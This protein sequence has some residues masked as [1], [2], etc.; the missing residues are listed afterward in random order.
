[1]L[2]VITLAV[3]TFVARQSCRK[4]KSQL[5][6]ARVQ[7]RSASLLPLTAPDFFTNRLCGAR[8]NVKRSRLTQNPTQSRRLMRWEKG[9]PLRTTLTE[10]K[11][12][13]TPKVPPVAAH[14]RKAKIATHRRD[15]SCSTSTS[16]SSALLI[17]RP[18]SEPDSSSSRTVQLPRT[19]LDSSP[20]KVSLDRATLHTQEHP[21]DDDAPRNRARNGLVGR[22][23]GMV[24]RPSHQ[25]ATLSR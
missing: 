15:V 6:G 1:M 13:A 18:S 3:K 7:R 20:Q 14:E 17:P 23:I 12:A 2:C 24:D 22:S 10:T 5:L 19:R 11:H 25:E 21:Q 16:Q 4:S 8:R 9:V